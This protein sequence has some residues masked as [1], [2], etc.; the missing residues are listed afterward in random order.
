MYTR[1]RSERE[2]INEA[3]KWARGKWDQ[4]YLRALQSFLVKSL[5]FP[6]RQSKK[7]CIY[8]IKSRDDVVASVAADD[9]GD[10]DMIKKG[11]WM[12]VPNIPLA[13]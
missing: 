10:V 12:I 13:K 4:R 3:V 6:R 11:E 8:N 2:E 1:K 9:G 7:K 5:S